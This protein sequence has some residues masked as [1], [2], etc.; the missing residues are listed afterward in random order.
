METPPCPDN[1]QM[2]WP[3]LAVNRRFTSRSFC[4]HPFAGTVQ[5]VTIFGPIHPNSRRPNFTQRD[6][7]LHIPM[8]SYQPNDYAM[9][10]RIERLKL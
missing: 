1:Q 6:D 8:P 3:L 2:N 10:I 9:V 5:K 7:G 4:T